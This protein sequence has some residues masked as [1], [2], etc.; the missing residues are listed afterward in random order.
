M[1]LQGSIGSIAS[2]LATLTAEQRGNLY[3][4]P[5]TCQAVLR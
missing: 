3:K 1:A 5:W 4:S 2:F